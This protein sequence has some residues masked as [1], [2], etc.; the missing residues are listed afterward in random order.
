MRSDD[1]KATGGHESR[2]ALQPADVCDVRGARPPAY[3][4]D[5]P[6]ESIAVDPTR[7]VQPVK[8]MQ[9]LRTNIEAKAAHAG[10]NMKNEQRALIQDH[11]GSL[12]PVVYEGGRQ[13]M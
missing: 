2:G 9:A 5:D 13:C 12:Q 4:C 3:V 8:L 1:D 6:E 10:Q 7:S 11:N